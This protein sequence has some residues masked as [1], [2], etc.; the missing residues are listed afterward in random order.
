MILVSVARPSS[1]TKLSIASDATWN[2]SAQTVCFMAGHDKGAFI[3]QSRTVTKHLLAARRFINFADQ[4]FKMVV[5]PHVF[6]QRRAHDGSPKAA[7][8]QYP[9]PAAS[10]DPTT[11]PSA[12]TASLIGARPKRS[13][14]GW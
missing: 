5:R 1:T 4:D 3:F 8:S 12:V 11:S 14:S 13:S 10:M 6:F 9:K 7:F 2:S